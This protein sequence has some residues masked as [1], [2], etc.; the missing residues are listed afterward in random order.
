LAEQRKLLI[1]ESRQ[2]AD[3]KA[4][5]EAAIARREHAELVAERGKLAMERMTVRAATAGKVLQLVARP[6]TRVTAMEGSAAYGAATIVTL[7]DPAMLQVRADVRLEDFSQVRP[8]QPVRIETA[9]AKTPLVGFV[10]Q[11]T[12][13]AN[14]Q[15]NTLEVKVAIQDPPATI[16]PEM[17]VT[18]T[19]LA[20]PQAK[21]DGDQEQSPERLLVPK[22]LIVGGEEGRF[23][24]IVS[25]SGTAE[26]R[27]IR[28]GQA[29]RDGLV[30]VVEGLNPTDKIISAGRE[31]LRDGAR[32][33]ATS[34]LAATGSAS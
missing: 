11:P 28:L 26:R 24:W 14:I 15:K 25:P 2:V 29:G 9:S 19:F 20:P 4:K 27:S 34:E 6:G 18:T 30:E 16:R 5:L 3:T 13:V 8:N 21:S 22:H 17:L 33:S 23:V 1:D 31:G 32:V 7:Y 10:L 12:S